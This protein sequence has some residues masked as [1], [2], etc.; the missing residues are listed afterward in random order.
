MYSENNFHC[1]Y[2]IMVHLQRQSIY[3]YDKFKNIN[4]GHSYESNN[5]KPVVSIWKSINSLSKL[6]FCFVV[7]LFDETPHDAERVVNGSVGL[8]E[9]QFVG[10]ADQHRHCLARVLNTSHL[11]S[12]KERLFINQVILS[13]PL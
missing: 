8:L 2:L 10:A 9:H 1:F 7:P 11:Q 3:L 13:K 12:H 4:R 5:S 6:I